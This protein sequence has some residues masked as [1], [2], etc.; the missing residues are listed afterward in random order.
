MSLSDRDAKLPSSSSGWHD[1]PLHEQRQ[2]RHGLVQTEVVWRAGLDR[3]TTVS[4]RFAVDAYDGHPGLM[5][6]LFAGAGTPDYA[7][8]VNR[9]IEESLELARTVMRAQG[10]PC[11][12][13][14]MYETS[15]GTWVGGDNCKA[16]SPLPDDWGSCTESWIPKY[17]K[18]ERQALGWKAGELLDALDDLHTAIAARPP[19][20]KQALYFMAQIVELRRDIEFELPLLDWN[21]ETRSAAR[22]IGD[23]I[24]TRTRRAEVGPGWL[25]DRWQFIET[26]CEEAVRYGTALSFADLRDLLMLEDQQRRR[27]DSV[28]PPHPSRLP[29][30]G[31]ILK[32]FQKLRRIGKIPPIVGSGVKRGRPKKSETN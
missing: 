28:V 19:R 6:Q 5:A 4:R 10:L 12:S 14:I 31:A 7:N 17:L 20:L 32:Q 24:W 18:I 27:A 23:A 22:I 15:D 26:A 3:R 13:R 9:M 21:I 1:L 11:G 8:L 25:R 2:L 29:T 16:P 30:G